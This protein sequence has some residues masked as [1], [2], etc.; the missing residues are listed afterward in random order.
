MNP[1]EKVCTVCWVPKALAYFARCGERRRSNCKE[2]D[3]RDRARR[4][5]E[6]EDDRLYAM[7]QAEI[8]RTLGISRSRVQQIEAG[9]LKKLRTALAEIERD[10]TL[11]YLPARPA[12]TVHLY[13]A[14][15]WR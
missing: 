2:C 14:G 6:R 1:G 15:G 11:A 12:L 9:A 3:N 7:S 10:E 5:R 4:H 8:A 13:L